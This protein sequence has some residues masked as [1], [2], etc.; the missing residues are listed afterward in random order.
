MIE[1]QDMKFAPRDGTRFLARTSR[2]EV[3]IAYY[4]SQRYYKTPKPYFAYERRTPPSVTEDRADQPTGWAA[5][6]RA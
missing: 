6:P 2:G 3:R 4:E 1:W 5:L